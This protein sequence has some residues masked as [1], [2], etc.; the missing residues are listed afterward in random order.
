MTKEQILSSA[1]ELLERK[2]S[3][4]IAMMED[5]SDGLANET[6]SSAGDK[7]ETSRAMSQQEIDKVSVQLQ[8]NKRQIALLP[9]LESQKASGR[10]ASGSLVRTTTGLFFIGI[11]LGQIEL[12]GTT[13]FCISPTSP[14][15]QKLLGMEAGSAYELNGKSESIIEVR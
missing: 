13:I 4:L 9:L 1:R 6:K 2:H 5:L 7:Y 8:E 15:A 14:L 3:E 12:S 11:P 10:I